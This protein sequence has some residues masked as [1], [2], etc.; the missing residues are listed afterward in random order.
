MKIRIYISLILLVLL[1]SFGCSGS[2]EIEMTEA[3]DAMENAKDIHADKY[4]STDFQQA[5][6]AWDHAQAAEK[7]GLTS[8]AKVLFT[9]ARIFFT[10]GVF[11]GSVPG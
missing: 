3:R 5:Q 11:S 1:A 10:P 7:E 8:K 9:S 4:A 6:E 2:S